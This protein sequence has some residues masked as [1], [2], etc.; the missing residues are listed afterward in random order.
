MQRSASQMQKVIFHLNVPP[1]AF[2][3]FA[4]ICAKKKEEEWF[5]EWRLNGKPK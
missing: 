1:T 4:V 3:V 2:I 5:G